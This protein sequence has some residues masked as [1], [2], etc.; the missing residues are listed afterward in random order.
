MLNFLIFYTFKISCS[1]E[2]SVKK[3][4][5]LRPSIT[6]LRMQVRKNKA[7]QKWKVMGKLK[8]SSLSRS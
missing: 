5:N 3:F 1:A 8:S 4:Y 7:S 2:L 6:E